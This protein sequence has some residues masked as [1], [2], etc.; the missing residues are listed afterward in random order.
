MFRTEKKPF[1]YTDV[2]FELKEDKSLTKTINLIPVGTY[3]GKKEEFVLIEKGIYFVPALGGY[4]KETAISKNDDCKET[5]ILGFEYEYGGSKFSSRNLG[6]TLLLGNNEVQY[7]V[8]IG[9]IDT[10]WYLEMK[11]SYT[12]EKNLLILNLTEGQTGG[13]YISE[14]IK[15]QNTEP[16]EIKFQYV[17]ELNSFMKP[18][19]YERFKN[20]PHRINKNECTIEYKKPVKAKAR[21]L[22]NLETKLS[23]IPDLEIEIQKEGFLCIREKLNQFQ[24]QWSC[25]NLERQF[26]GFEFFHDNKQESEIESEKNIQI[27]LI[28]SKSFG[29]KGINL[30]LY[31][32]ISSQISTECRDN[33][34]IKGLQFAFG[35][36]E[37]V[38]NQWNQKIHLTGLQA[39]GLWNESHA[40]NGIQ[41]GS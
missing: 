9:G 2:F 14:P 12:I 29:F 38:E 40:I 33:T 22:P 35:I 18:A 11:G 41:M 3:L 7:R 8:S 20:N 15:A 28:S 34:D 5:K 26:I 16:R 1:V 30:G 31:K 13:F 25:K 10:S 39:A 27:N 17:P 21:S 36:N 23:E 4:L 19:A 24:T 37:Q 6:E 32:N